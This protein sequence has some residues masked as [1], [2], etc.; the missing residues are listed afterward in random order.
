M[1]LRSGIPAQ[2]AVDR[3]LSTP[4]HRQIYE[5]YRAAI[6]AG[7]LRAGDRL[8]STRD[9]ARELGVSRL[10]ALE[11]FDQLLAEGYCESR[12]G[13]GTWVASD[14]P[15]ARARK[16][17]SPTTGASGRRGRRLARASALLERTVPTPWL[18]PNGAFALG[19]AAFEA[20]PQAVWTKLLR[21]QARKV[22]RRELRY[23]DPMGWP[24]LREALAHFLGASRGVA[25]TAAEI[26]IVSGSQQALWIAAQALVDRGDPVWHEDP[27]YW[28]PATPSVP[29]GP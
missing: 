26:L 25:A 3:R 6:L 21:E 29:P 24:P 17:S 12:V 8:P 10:P 7:R 23:S 27:G 5:G 18:G 28:G 16:A 13:S 19:D 14:L 1:K 11:A 22:S 2:F 9:L 15:G 20:F 4:L